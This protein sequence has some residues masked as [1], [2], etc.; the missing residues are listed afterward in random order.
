[1]INDEHNGGAPAESQTES[2]PN[3][4]G[5]WNLDPV[6]IAAGIEK[7]PAEH[8]EDLRFAYE[9]ARSQQW[10]FQETADKYQVD[11]ST[12]SRLLNGKYVNPAN[13]SPL[14][15]PVVL[16]SIVRQIRAELEEATQ[17]KNVRILTPTVQELFTMFDKVREDHTIGYVYGES[18][19][20][21]TEAGKW[22][23]D[24][25]NHG[26]TIYVDL[27]DCNGVQD[28]W[29][30]FARALYLSADCAA[31]KLIPRI[32]NALKPPGVTR[33]NRFVI[34]DEFHALTYTYFRGSS[35]RIINVLKAI[36]D[37]TGCP[38]VVIATPTARDEIAQ[39]KERKF[40]QQIKRRG[41]LEYNYPPA[42]A[43][44]DMRAFAQH[45]RLE[46]PSYE[47]V[48]AKLANHPDCERNKHGAVKD[49][50]KNNRLAFPDVDHLAALED[51]AWNHGVKRLVCQ[52]RDAQ[53]LAKNARREVRWADFEKAGRIYTKFSTPK[54]V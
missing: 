5:G 21:K 43:V 17:K 2:Q 46:L 48:A 13:N 39:G 51:I 26:Q 53:K 38:L 40:L 33:S 35:V 4:S 7:C 8:R 1:M 32:Y 9:Y 44:G 27:Q 11:K 15:P 20:G 47:E 14:K 18:H 22:Y 16:L 29:R 12:L 19:L 45:F 25:H 52:L 10:T 34:C 31:Y 28:V 23:R 3:L 6:L 30:A 50:W 49:N 24:D 41:L 42:I 36:H 54:D 37:N